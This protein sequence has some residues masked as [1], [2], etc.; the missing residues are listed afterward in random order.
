MHIAYVTK[1]LGIEFN[2]TIR[3]HINYVEIEAVAMNV[4]PVQP[5]MQL[6]VKTDVSVDEFLKNY[7]TWL[8]NGYRRIKDAIT[9][10]LATTKPATQLRP[11]SCSTCAYWGSVDGPDGKRVCSFWDMPD[12]ECRTGNAEYCSKGYIPEDQEHVPAWDLES[13]LDL[14]E[15]ARHT[16][17]NRYLHELYIK[18]DDYSVPSQ[19][20]DMFKHIDNSE[21]I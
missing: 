11:E 8:T 16:F 6:F 13:P 9:S 4:E 2:L 1:F 19:I 18:D 20:T 12:R 5:K 14:A 21:E 10:G 15:G 17:L 7:G 3:K